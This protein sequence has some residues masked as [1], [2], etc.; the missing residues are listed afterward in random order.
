MSSAYSPLLQ[1]K[2]ELSN[3]SS[4]IT[5]LAADPKI[6][7]ILS[8]ITEDL[9][10]GFLAPLVSYGPRMTGTY[11]CEKAAQ[12]I[13]KQFQSMNLQTWVQNWT[14]FGNIYHPR[15]F[16]SQNVEG[17][18]PGIVHDEN[19]IVFTAH[20]DTVARTP[21]A[22]DDGSGVAAVL[23]AAYVLSQFTFNHTVKFVAFSG[24]EVGLLG[25]HAYARE[26]YQNH[27]RIVVNLNADMI[28]HATTA[29]GGRRMGL[30]VSEDAWWVFTIFSGINTEYSINFEIS[31]GDIDRDGR[32]WSDY[33]SFIE[34]G[35]EALACWGGEPDPSMHTPLDTLDNVNLSYLV[36]TTRLIV[37]TLAFLADCSGMHPQVFVESPRMGNLYFEGMKRITVDDLHTVVLDDI[38]IWADV[39]NDSFPVKRA[40]FYFDDILEYTDTDYPFKWY[41]HKR[42]LGKHRITIIIYDQIGRKSSVWQDIFLINVLLQK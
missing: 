42:S 38:W 2:S 6:A 5:T 19:I 12:F 34:Y 31:A 10:R 27:E 16:R 13:H 11:G 41:F 18:L 20:Y 37:G 1:Q 36:N 30:S 22:N 4:K 35:W 8:L 14:A 9:L 17:T 26:A 3:N 40:E 29:E 7:T 39:M 33:F 32:G 23:A 15:L 21:G 24:E 25:S 28:G